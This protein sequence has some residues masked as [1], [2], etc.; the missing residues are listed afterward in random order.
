MVNILFRIHSSLIHRQVDRYTLDKYEYE[1]E[2]AYTEQPTRICYI[3]ICR[4]IHLSYVPLLIILRTPV[5]SFEYVW[6]GVVT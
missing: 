6:R 3:H 1:T 5:G 4:K 2:K